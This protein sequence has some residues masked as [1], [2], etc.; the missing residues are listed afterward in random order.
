MPGDGQAWQQMIATEQ[1]AMKAEEMVRHGF[2]AF[3]R[4][5]LE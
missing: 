3:P 4:C 1:A 2:G 5:R